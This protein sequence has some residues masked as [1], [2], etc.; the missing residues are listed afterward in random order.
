MGLIISIIGA[1][2]LL[3]WSLDLAQP[4]R[5]ALGLLALPP[6]TA[7]GILLAGLALSL[8]GVS[9]LGWLRALL[10]AAVCALGGLMLI[11]VLL[12][13]TVFLDALLVPEQARAELSSPL[14]NVALALA[15]L[16]LSHL[17]LLSSIAWLTAVGQAVAAFVALNGLYALLDTTAAG[18]FSLAE[19]GPAVV[20]PELT[21]IALGVGT[22]LAEPARGAMKVL[23]GGGPGG[24]AFV[25][26][27]PLIALVP[28]V[29]GGLLL[30]AYAAGWRVAGLLPASLALLN[31]ALFWLLAAAMD[32]YAAGRTRAMAET[33]EHAMR[34]EVLL[35][36]ARRLNAQLDV[37]TVLEAVCDTARVA[38]AVP[39][40][41][42]TL[43]DPQGRRLLP[44][45]S[46]GLSPVAQAALGSV[47]RAEFD[48]LVAAHGSPLVLQDLR[49]LP[50]VPNRRALELIDARTLVTA[51]LRWRDTLIGTLTIGSCGTVRQ[52]SRQEIEL[53]CGLAD[54]AAQAIA[55]AR[56]HARTEAQALANA[57]LV[58]ATDR[59]LRKV[60]A[61]HEIDSAIL[62][63]RSRDRTLATVLEQACAELDTPAALVWLAEPGTSRM[64]AG[65]S[66]GTYTNWDGV[67]LDLRNTPL[68][69]QAASTRQATWRVGAPETL[70]GP[71][72]VAEDAAFVAAAPL[73]AN[74]TLLGVLEV[75]DRTPRE[76][77][78][79]WLQFLMTLAG[80]AAIAVDYLRALEDLAHANEAL[81][82]AYD[83]TLAGWAR[84]LDLRD[85][86]TAGHCE[87]VTALTVRL[88]EIWGLPEWELTQI[89]RGALLHDIGKIGVPDAILRKPGPLTPEE[90]AVMEQHPTYAYEWLSSIDFLRPA[91]D[92]PYGH[93]ERWD[94]TG[95]PRGLR[96]EQIPL[97]ARLFAVVDVWDALTSDRPYRAA[98]S[99]EQALA[100]LEEHA[101]T[102][103][104]PQVVAA[105][106]G[107]IVTGAERELMI[108]QQEPS[109]QQAPSGSVESKAPARTSFSPHYGKAPS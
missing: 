74:S 44:G 21:L 57:H 62:T 3:G 95:Y 35:R 37:K 32:R 69:S 16:G 30:Q 71:H 15:L 79:E 53:L 39:F 84:M 47:P 45:A 54:L 90:R 97:A 75:F 93:H 46:A 20:W 108:G 6:S 102:H 49:R 99:P 66:T 107:L 67:T 104:D 59:R 19:A 92:I 68:L 81:V 29:P 77:D 41:T 76:P 34:A 85:H 27:L 86:D 1:A 82:A 13:R 22:C 63:S 28:L 91:L 26:L 11:D 64:R 10:A 14:P 24:T 70:G 96:G 9:R 58:A 72:L 56:L 65:P 18:L 33:R 40:V 7:A 88:G 50:A 61:L 38:F 109:P 94:G 23:T 98:W 101:G 42:I 105:F 78:A 89:R 83:S 87:R 36:A 4:Q 48:A 55:N 43:A 80:Q 17:L 2:A 106:R 51:E 12:A 60:H 25:R 103:F 52:F 73:M 100:Y 5:V 8:A 31:L